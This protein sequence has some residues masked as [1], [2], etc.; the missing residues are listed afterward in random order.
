MCGA[1]TILWYFNVFYRKAKKPK[2]ILKIKFF[3]FT[4][5]KEVESKLFSD[6]SVKS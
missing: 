5:T 6:K 3:N 1:K 4:K 2:D